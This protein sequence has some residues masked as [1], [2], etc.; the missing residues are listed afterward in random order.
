MSTYISLASWTEMG[1]REVKDSPRRLDAAKALAKQLGGE[2]THFYMTMG[3]CDMVVVGEFPD[4]A[5]AAKFML[6]LTKAGALRA[7]TLKAYAEP[8][9][10]AIMGALG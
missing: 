8:E 4:D 6:H 9:Y 5:T 3:E 10:R 7:R 2:I 1:A